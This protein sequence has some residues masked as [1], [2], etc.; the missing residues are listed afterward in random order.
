MAAT[1]AKEGTEA[2]YSCSLCSAIFDAQ[3]KVITAIPTIAKDPNNHAK[4]PS[5][6]Y[7]GEYK[8]SYAVGDT[9]SMGEAVYKIKCD[10]CDGSALSAEQ[11]KLVT[12]TY[13]TTGADKFVVG[14]IGGKD[15]KVTAKYSTYSITFDVTVGKRTTTINGVDDM[16]KDCGFL[17]FDTLEG[18]SATDGKLVYT[19]SDTK[20]GTYLNA[21]AFNAA[22][23][24]GM[25]V[26][27]ADKESK[28]YYAKATV[29]AGD[30]YEAASKDFTIT[31]KHLKGDAWTESADK[32]SDIF[33]C[34]DKNPVTFKK[35]VTATNQDI[36]LNDNGTNKFAIS[37]EGIGTYASVKSIKY[38]EYD[39]GTNIADLAIS[40]ALKADNANHGKGTIVV[41]VHSDAISG[42]PETDH[43]VNVPV[44]MI[45]KQIAS[46]EDFKSYVQPNADKRVVEGYYKQTANEITAERQSTAMK[47]SWTVSWDDHFNGTYD[48]NGKT[49]KLNSN[50]PGGG[51]FGN[52]GNDSKEVGATIKN[53][54][55]IDGWHSDGQDVV[56]LGRAISYTTFENVTFTLNGSGSIKKEQNS[57]WI[58]SQRMQNTT[59]K[60][61]KFNASTS[62][63]GSIFGGHSKNF[64]DNTFENSEL[65]V[66]SYMCLWHTADAA[67]D[68]DANK[69]MT[70]EG[71]TINITPAA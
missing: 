34:Q 65:N 9:F 6:T 30:E 12:Y 21:A 37:L 36:L 4:T 70:A 66:K 41:T 51:I 26:G 24:D 42:A 67:A 38:G 28:V 14:D 68:I 62:A 58:A 50:I 59:Y 3:K 53:V 71:L 18:A 7:S 45:T 54:T 43:V 19:F 63:L 22:H 49:L 23:P 5:L 64:K 39:L 40:D 29:D 32:S 16:N 10:D 47:E 46:A 17:A 1:C 69:V 52:L 35:T 48:G 33:G 61:C 27:S 44:T 11:T 13:P 56:L 20:D 55:I 25:T 31:V 60:N 2:Y 8:K 15:L 57:G